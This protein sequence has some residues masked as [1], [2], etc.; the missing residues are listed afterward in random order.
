[1]D[2]PVLRRGHGRRGGGAWRSSGG[3]VIMFIVLYSC[4][5]FVSWDLSFYHICQLLVGEVEKVWRLASTR[6]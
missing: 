4:R 1:M 2:L 6:N 5:L 3:Y